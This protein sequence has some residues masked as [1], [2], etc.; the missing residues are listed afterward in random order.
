MRK[1]Q[2]LALKNLYVIQSI[3]PVTKIPNFTF[4]TIVDIKGKPIYFKK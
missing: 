4:D 2:L 1:K 3:H